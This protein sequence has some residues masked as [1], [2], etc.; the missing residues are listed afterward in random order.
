M[1]GVA[2]EI[3]TAQESRYNIITIIIHFHYC[4]SITVHL[5][6]QGMYIIMYSKRN[7]K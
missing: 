7:G 3:A 1:E 4:N 5:H 2:L 6:M